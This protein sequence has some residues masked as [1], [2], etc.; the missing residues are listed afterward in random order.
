MNRGHILWVTQTAMF[1]A[2]L[3]SAQIFTGQ[4]GQFVT[5]SI[6][7]FILV[8]ACILVGLPAAAIVGVVSPLIAFLI[9]GRPVFPVLIPFVMVGNVALV[10]AIHFIAAKSYL[11]LTHSSYA[12]AVV[13]VI[14]GAV[15]KFLVLWVGIVHVAIPFLIP[16]ILLPQV[17]A[18]S[19]AFSWPQLVTALI[20]S[21]VAMAVMPHVSRAIHHTHHTTPNTPHQ[22]Q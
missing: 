19:L 21:G 16:G 12:R 8:A 20:G 4:F 1:I 10:T 14:V 17:N 5:G 11:K 13:A 15:L 3:V 7:N 22:G 6:V 9:T 18:L 2:L